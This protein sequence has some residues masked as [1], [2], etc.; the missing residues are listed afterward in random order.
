MLK[1]YWVAF[2]LYLPIAAHAATDLNM[3]C[4]LSVR[5]FFAPLVQNR[6]IIKKPYDVEE[7]SINYFK[8]NFF[9]GLT[10]HGMKVT[11]IFG[12]T[13]D[14]L[15]FEKRGSPDRPG[16]QDVYG[17]IVKEGLADTQAQ[18]VSVGATDARAIRIDTKSTAISCKGVMR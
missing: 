5:D 10:A 2:A 7:T 11:G 17:V 1:K 13:D 14:P 4:G 6:L 15:F 8:P 9:A 16:S 12:Y 3:S 18:L